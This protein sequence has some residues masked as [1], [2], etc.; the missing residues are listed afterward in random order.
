[1]DINDKVLMKALIRAVGGIAEGQDSVTIGSPTKAQVKVYNDCD[2][3]RAFEAKVMEH[4]ALAKK[5]K[6]ELNGDGE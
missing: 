1:M 5:A 2:T 3:F 4:I 6:T